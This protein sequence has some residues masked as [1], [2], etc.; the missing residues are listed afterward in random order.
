[1]VANLIHFDL[2]GLAWLNHRRQDGRA[3]SGSVDL[4]I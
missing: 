4:R 3:V 1:M 2:I